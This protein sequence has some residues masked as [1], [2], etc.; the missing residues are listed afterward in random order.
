MARLLRV[1]VD[2]L[3]PVSTATDP[4]STATDRLPSLLSAFL[5]LRLVCDWTR[6]GE[7]DASRLDAARPEQLSSTRRRLTPG[8]LDLSSTPHAGLDPSSTPHA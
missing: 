8:R 4:P 3:P 2:R 6:D 5:L 1:E 7:I